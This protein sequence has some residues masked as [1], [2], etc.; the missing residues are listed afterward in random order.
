VY[1]FLQIV[2]QQA[3][4]LGCTAEVFFARSRPSYPP[5][6]C[7]EGAYHYMQRVAADMLGQENVKL[8]LRVM[9]AE[10]FAM[11]LQRIPGA[12]LFVGAANA[13]HSAHNDLHSPHFYANED[14]L[15][16]GAALH[17]RLALSFLQERAA[18]DLGTN[19][20]SLSNSQ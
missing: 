18:A 6:V 9:Y 17:A 12:F 15:P 20:I 8:S 7:D 19:G 4:A 2:V 1:V 10:D 11:Y 3:A 13:T 5:V 16:I 14:V